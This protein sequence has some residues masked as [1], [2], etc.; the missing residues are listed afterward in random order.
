MLRVEVQGGEIPP[1]SVPVSFSGHTFLKQ[2]QDPHPRMS[3]SAQVLCLPP[4]AIGDS[5]F[6]TISLTNLGCAPVHFSVGNENMPPQLCV[7]PVSGVVP[8][9]QTFVLAVRFKATSAGPV[10]GTALLVLNENMAAARHISIKAAG[11]TATLAVNVGLQLNCP[12]TC[13]G[14]T[15]KRAFGLSNLSRVPVVFEWDL[16][17]LQDSPFTLKPA[18]GIL[19]G[20]TDCEITCLFSPECAGS[21]SSRLLCRASMT[22]GTGASEGLSSLVLRL[23]GDGTEPAVTVD[24]Q[25]IDFGSVCIGHQYSTSLSLMNSS[26]GAARYVLE[27]NSGGESM[28]VAKV[29]GESLHKEAPEGSAHALL[30]ADLPSGTIPARSVMALKLTLFPRVPGAWEGRLMCRISKK[31]HTPNNKGLTTEVCRLLVCKY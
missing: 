9:G 31:G 8:A 4:C 6:S 24:Q 19:R 22:G 17:L 1:F 15:S 2:P 28:P 12:P 11:F 21:F 26:P 20:S 25:A 5:T 27:L 18:S 7:F 29:A 3:L 30:C 10:L 13:A 14:A 16:A 23:T